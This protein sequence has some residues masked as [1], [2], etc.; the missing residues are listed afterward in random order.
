VALKQAPDAGAD[1]GEQPRNL[2]V[3][4]R[5]GGVEAE[6]TGFALSEDPVEPERVEVNIQIDRAPKPLNDGE[7]P[8]LPIADPPLAR[9]DASYPDD[10][11]SVLPTGS[12]G[13]KKDKISG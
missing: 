5:R 4:G 2:L 10:R 9:L 13:C 7:A 1:R 12:N 3:A 11:R 6:G 8:G